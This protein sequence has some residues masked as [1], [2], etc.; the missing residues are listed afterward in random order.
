MFFN[1]RTRRRKTDSHIVAS[2]ARDT[3]KDTV[4]HLGSN[5]RTHIPQK[6]VATGKHLERTLCHFKVGCQTLDPG[7]R[8]LH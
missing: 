1:Q 4:Y 6:R 2:V 3:A 8:L 5:F 7:F